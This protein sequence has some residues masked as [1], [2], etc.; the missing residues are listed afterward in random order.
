MGPWGA[1]V[2]LKL[3]AA[4]LIAS[5]PLGS[6]NAVCAED[7]LKTPHEAAVVAG[8]A[9]WCCTPV[10]LRG[11]GMIIDMESGWAPE[12]APEDEDGT[13]PAGGDG[14][15][16]LCVLFLLTRDLAPTDALRSTTAPVAGLDRERE[17][18]VLR[19]APELGC[20]PT[21]TPTPPAEAPDAPPTIEGENGEEGTTLLRSEGE[22]V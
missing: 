12:V 2:L 20:T 22:P 16:M 17:R 3:V 10:P 11:S 9:T 15:E 7:G 1:N 6:E 4:V 21:P 18:E 14:E 13:I 5:P 8:L 19:I